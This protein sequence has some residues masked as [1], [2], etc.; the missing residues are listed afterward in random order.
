MEKF[1]LPPDAMLTILRL[2]GLTEDTRL[3]AGHTL[4]LPILQPPPYMIFCR[5]SSKQSLDVHVQPIDESSVIGVLPPD[6]ELQV[7]DRVQQPGVLWLSVSAQVEGVTIS[8][9]WVRA[10]ALDFVTDCDMNSASGVLF[11]L[12]LIPVVPT[13]PPPSPTATPVL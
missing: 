13:V 6:T 8:G 2:N 10:D 11:P 3:T 7:G 12:T 1:S 4:L 5:V 9:G